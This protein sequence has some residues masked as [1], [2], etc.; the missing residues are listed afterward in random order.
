M[1]ISSQEK[2]TMSIG[3]FVE[4]KHQ[5]TEEEIHQ[6]IGA[7]LSVWEELIRYIREHY[8]SDE[9]FKFLY[10]KK[11]GWALRFRKRGQLLTSLYPTEGGFTVQINLGPDAIDQTRNMELGENIRGVI[12]KA[13]PYPEGRWLFIPITSEDD[14]RD[15][16]Q[17]LAL[18]VETKRL[19]Y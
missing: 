7:K 10:G 12:E 1:K 6:V 11:Y 3:A 14:V 19:R 15:I 9:D 8:P 13:T 5:P 18:R 4:K 2:H 17:L 16:H